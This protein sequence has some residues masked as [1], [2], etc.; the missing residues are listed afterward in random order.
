MTARAERTRASILSAFRRWRRL[1]D[2]WV[3]DLAARCGIS[4]GRAI[5]ARRRLLRLGCIRLAGSA[6][7]GPRAVKVY[8]FMRELPGR[9]PPSDPLG[10]AP[11][12]GSNRA[13]DRGRER[14]C[15]NCA[16]RSPAAEAPAGMVPVCC[17]PAPAGESDQATQTPERCHA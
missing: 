8:E 15:D 5:Y 16:S 10:D 14:R 11:I 4:K 13:L 17:P 2:H 3:A 7:E 6:I 12:L 1:S 9:R